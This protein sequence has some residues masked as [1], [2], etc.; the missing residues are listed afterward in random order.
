[1]IG[2]CFHDGH[3]I[4]T[5]VE[6]LAIAEEVT[7]VKPGDVLVTQGTLGGSDEYRLLVG[8]AGA[9]MVEQQVEQDGHD[10]RRA[11]ARVENSLEPAWEVLVEARCGNRDHAE[12]NRGGHDNQVHVVSIVNLR[13][14]ADTTGRDR[15]KQYQ[16]SPSENGSRHRSNQSPHHRQQ[17]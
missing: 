4:A 3:F 11:D 1:M 12:T 2:L 13:Q 8:V 6:Q 5:A 14:G 7:I 16:S 15:A 10:R 17:P 9:Q